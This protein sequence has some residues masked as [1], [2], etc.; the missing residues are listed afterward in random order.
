MKGSSKRDPKI[1]KF[2]GGST[3]LVHAPPKLKI[4]FLKKALQKSAS[5]GF[6][7][8][9]SVHNTSIKK[10]LHQTSYNETFPAEDVN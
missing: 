10:Q 4:Q 5:P 9:F 1:Q 7:S 3:Q 8:F 2:S 6:I